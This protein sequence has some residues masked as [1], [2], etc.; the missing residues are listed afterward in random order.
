MLAFGKWFIDECVLALAG[1]GG[2]DA[3]SIIVCLLTPLFCLLGHGFG[4]QP[5][6][7][8]FI[9]ALNDRIVFPIQ[10]YSPFCSILLHFNQP[11]SISNLNHGHLH[12]QAYCPLYH[13]LP[14]PFP[15]HFVASPFH[16]V[17]SPFQ[18]FPFFQQHPT[19]NLL[20]P[21]WCPSWRKPGTATECSTRTKRPWMLRDKH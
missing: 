6:L 15:I 17:A 11:I 7:H 8:G 5:G 2:S 3:Q 4:L 16:F 21:Q 10:I 13:F 12:S 9:W 1:S 18:Y 14:Y 19:P 20:R